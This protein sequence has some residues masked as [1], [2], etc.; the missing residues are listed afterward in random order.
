VAVNITTRWHDFAALI[1]GATIITTLNS[2][3]RIH[4]VV[5]ANHAREIGAGP[6][7]TTAGIIRNTRRNVWETST[8]GTSCFSLHVRA[9]IIEVNMKFL[10]ARDYDR[11]SGIASDRICERFVRVFHANG[12]TWIRCAAVRVIARACGAQYTIEITLDAVSGFA[13][14][15]GCATSIWVA[16]SRIDITA[17]GGDARLRVARHGKIILQMIDSADARRKRDAAT[18][19]SPISIDVV[20]CGRSQAALIYGATVSST[21]HFV[22]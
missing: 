13:G 7:D 17:I 15:E 2:V 8:G 1:N 3:R 22:R 16:T 20:A 19:T 10:V 5:F 4:E 11:F 12:S 18:R 14:R 6:I 21:L 9:T